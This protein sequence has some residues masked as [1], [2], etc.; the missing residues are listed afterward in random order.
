MLKKILVMMIGALF[1][2]ATSSAQ[3]KKFIL[4][5]SIKDKT[6]GLIKMGWVAADGNLIQ[7]S[8]VIINGAFVFK[9]AVSWPVMAF[10]TA[11]A[12]GF[13]FNDA[14]SATFFLEAGKL[15]LQVTANDFANMK[16]EGS[17]THD[18][19]V[20]LEK[21][22]AV[23]TG[24]LKQINEEYRKAYEVY[25]D[26]KKQAKPESELDILKLK[27]EA[28]KEKGAAARA[29]STEISKEYM[30]SHPD[31]YL[32]VYLAYTMFPFM[33]LSEAQVL[34]AGFTDRVKQS[35][36]GKGFLKS[37]REVEAGSPGS[38]AAA[39][40]KADINGDNL[41][42]ADFK[43]NKYVLLDFWASWCVPCRKG[44]PHLLSLYNKYKDKG[45]EIIGISDDD[46][47]H[48]A[49]KKAVAMDKIGVWKHILTGLKRTATGFDKS[50][51]ISAAYGI[52][53]L[54][55]KILVDKNGV[56][57]GR[58]GGGGEEEE[59]LDKMLEK[60]FGS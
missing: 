12:D 48:E 51:Y 27:A 46:N 45:F 39:F 44:N 37:I 58:Y 60:I 29:R 49:W 30:K 1:T 7:D 10:I 18:E 50:E 38:V 22:K 35:A 42:L 41:S 56:I 57:V 13:K 2:C 3:L 36:D 4:N 21:A 16:L 17:A 59:D 28:I 9:G 47:N 53:S 54:P 23:A 8:A 19:F 14:N 24:E 6:S 33:S 11:N 52:R 34:Y 32:S 25:L 5:G 15:T 26:A 20:G 55:T 31:S 43:G 40:A